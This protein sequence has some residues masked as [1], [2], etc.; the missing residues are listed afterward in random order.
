MDWFKTRMGA[1]TGRKAERFV[2]SVPEGEVV[3]AVGDVHGRADLLRDLLKKIEADWS[4]SPAQTMRLL[5]L[6]DYVDRGAESKGVLDILVGL[7][8]QGGER[9]IAMKGNHEEA[10]L[11]FLLDP[12]TGAAWAEHGGRETLVSYGVTPPR[13]R[14]DDEAWKEARDAFA[15]VIPAS[16]LSFLQNLQLFATVGDYVFV[17][18][19]LRPGTPLD[20]QEEHDLLWIRKEFLDSPAWT[21]HVVVHGHTPMAEPALRPGRIGVDTGAYATGVLTAV[22]LEGDRRSFIRT[23]V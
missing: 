16:H 6:G 17:H 13:G 4:A 3:Y 18:A 11:G 10:L 15:K 2:A 5:M 22:R 19:G 20:Q 14:G 9:M 12:T 23:G 21:N 1:L 8:S 7:V